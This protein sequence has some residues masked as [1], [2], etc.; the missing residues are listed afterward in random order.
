MPM[1]AWAAGY[2]QLLTALTT[3]KQDDDSEKVVAV[4]AALTTEK[5]RP[6]R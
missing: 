4:V 3:H 2:S 1:G 6:A 5:L